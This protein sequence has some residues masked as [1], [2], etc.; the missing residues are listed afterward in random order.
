MLILEINSNSIEALI[1]IVDS[2]IDNLNP[3]KSEGFE[4]RVDSI[5]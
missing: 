4:K 1:R 5:K 2:L 3:P